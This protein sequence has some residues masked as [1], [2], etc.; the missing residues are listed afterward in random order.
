MTLFHIK[1]VKID[2]KYYPVYFKPNF[3]SKRIIIKFTD[4]HFLITAPTEVFTIEDYYN[5][6]VET[7]IYKLAAKLKKRK[8]TH[9]FYSLSFNEYNHKID[10]FGK[11]V[12]LIWNYTN[13]KE[14]SFSFSKKENWLKIYCNES[15]R[16]DHSK[17]KT[18]FINILKRILNPYIAEKQTEYAQKMGIFNPLFGISLKK[19]AW[20]TNHKRFNRTSTIKYDVKLVALEPI[21]IDYVIVHE[22]NHVLH[23]NHS[24]QFYNNGEMFLKNFKALDRKMNKNVVILDRDLLVLE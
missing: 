12:D 13:W 18:V 10:L 23:G 17:R 4:K 14:Y 7:S 21:F 1:D 15:L 8:K 2:D 3:R 9:N 11:K 20:G 22:L 19:T 5:F 24:D 6:N 16:I